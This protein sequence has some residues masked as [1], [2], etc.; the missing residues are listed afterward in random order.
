M[1]QADA[2]PTE[3]HPLGLFREPLLAVLCCSPDKT[4]AEAISLLKNLLVFLWLINARRLRVAAVVGTGKK[5]GIE[6][7]ETMV[8]EEIDVINVNT[9]NGDI[10]K[11]IAAGADS[12]MIDSIFTGSAESPGE[13]MMYKG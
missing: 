6:R 13:I 10:A 8:R 4:V 2:L 1:P 3:P 9:A 11:A 5:D 12:V 7:C